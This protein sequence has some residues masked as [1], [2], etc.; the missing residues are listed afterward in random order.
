MLCN[1][2]EDGEAEVDE[3]EP[4]PQIAKPFPGRLAGTVRG[5]LSFMAEK[6]DAMDSAA[7]TFT[8]K[9]ETTAASVRG[10]AAGT[11]ATAEEKAVRHSKQLEGMISSKVAFFEG[12]T[13]ATYSA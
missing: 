12:R 8:Q 2:G 5:S 6:W 13:R 4:V 3:A 11:V 7:E 9:V 1:T 10:K